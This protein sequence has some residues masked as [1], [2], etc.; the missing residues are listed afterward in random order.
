MKYERTKDAIQIYDL[1]EYEGRTILDFMNDYHQSRK[2][3]YLLIQNHQVILD[4]IIVKNMNTV[5]GRDSQLTIRLKEEGI[6][7]APS[8][9]ECHVVYQNPF[10]YIVHKE[11]GMIIH[12]SP[13]D[14]NCLNAQAARWQ[15]NH[16]IDMPVRP[17]HRLD[18]ETQGL[19]IYSKIPFFQPWLDEELRQK[20]I[21]RHYLAVCYGNCPAGKQYTFQQPIGRDR[22]QSGKYRISQNGKSAFTKA[23]CIAV[24]KPYVLFSC[25]IETGRTHQIRVHL[26]EAGFPI[27]NDPLYGRKSKDF[28]DMGLCADQIAFRDPLTRKK[29]TIHDDCVTIPAFFGI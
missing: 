24:R 21:H 26:S 22:H 8:E 25:V 2:N 23:A 6:D 11:P 17:I 4:G 5:I 18:R 9:K 27:V 12:S 13:E 10:L 29:H 1:K 14:T 19:V 16:E 28:K 3:R 20:K 7:W 15:M